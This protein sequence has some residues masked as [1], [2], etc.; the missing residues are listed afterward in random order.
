MIMNKSQCSHI[1]YRCRNPTPELKGIK[2]M[3]KDLNGKEL[4]KGLGQH[5][6]SGLYF[7]R[8][9]VR[10]E[11]ITKYFTTVIEAKRWLKATKIEIETGRNSFR[12]VTVDDW[13]EYWIKNS[14]EGTVAQNT[15]TNYKTRYKYNI[16]P[17]I[18]KMYVDTVTPDMCQQVLNDMWKSGAAYGTMKLARIT[19]HAIF[20]GAVQ[21]KYILDNP[22]NKTVKCKG[23]PKTKTAESEERRVLT[24]EEQSVFFEKAKTTMYYLYWKLMINTGLR[25]GECSG[26]KWSD[27]D[28][29]KKQLYVKRTLNYDKEKNGFYLSDPKTRTSMR[30]VPLNENAIQALKEQ[31]I[32]QFKLRS[33]SKCWCEQEDFKDLIFTSI[34]GQPLG[35]GTLAMNLNR[36]VT[37]I[38]NDRRATAKMNGTDEY[39]EFEPLYPHALRHT[40]AT[41]CIEAGIQPK[42]LQKIMGHSTLGVTMD[43]YV[44][45]TD[46]FQKEELKKLENIC[47][48]MA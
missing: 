45:V 36:I 44:H 3:G 18:G 24:V 15:L 22:V 19:M 13:F 17:T 21:A 16:K 46:D 10:G 25:S 28:W 4:G 47:V 27:I 20:D 33:K 29:D 37:N 35:H 11:R 14:K 7:A 26:L 48:K 23:K 40:F 34:N 1:L 2:K 31:K 43:L 42:V 9:T 32:E 8:I 12:R 30:T 6:A 5:K 38:N 41:R 39:E